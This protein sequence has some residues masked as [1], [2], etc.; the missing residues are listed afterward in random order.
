[1]RNKMSPYNGLA[2]VLL[3]LMLVFAGLAVGHW[4]SGCVDRRAEDAMRQESDARAVSIVDQ[5]GA[6]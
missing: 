5:W 3:Y 2:I 4:V 6:K 1:M